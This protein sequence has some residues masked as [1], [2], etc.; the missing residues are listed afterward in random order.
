[1]KLVLS[2]VAAVAA[3]APMIAAQPERIVN[4]TDSPAFTFMGAL[5][6][7]N[8]VNERQDGKC[9]L[10]LL[11]PYY[12]LTAAICLYRCA[13][14]INCVAF[15]PIPQDLYLNN[16]DNGRIVV[17]G[18]DRADSSQFE[19]STIAGVVFHPD[20]AINPV[21]Y[22]NPNNLA[23]LRLGQPMFN[24]TPVTLSNNSAEINDIVELLGWGYTA[25]QLQSVVL[26][27][28]VMNV[29]AC[30]LPE[31]IPPFFCTQGQNLQNSLDSDACLYDQG[32]PALITTPA[33]LQQIG[34][35]VSVAPDCATGPQPQSTLINME[36]YLEWI[37]NNTVPLNNT[38][39][40]TGLDGGTPT[41]IIDGAAVP[42]I[43]VQSASSANTTATL[44]LI[45]ETFISNGTGPI[46]FT[47]TLDGVVILT[48]TQGDATPALEVSLTPGPH[49]LVIQS[50]DATGRTGFRDV[51]LIIED[52]VCLPWGCSCVLIKRIPRAAWTRSMVVWCKQN[53][54]RI[55][56]NPCSAWKCSCA[57]LKRWPAAHFT[58][59]I[60]MWWG[61]FCTAH[62]PHPY[63]SMY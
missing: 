22:A 54:P 59:L 1:M 14:E 61:T 29:T 15:E 26:Q 38:L 21:P 33:G 48:W 12:A 56:V 17:G 44:L 37:I 7:Q 30:E 4:G 13:D 39:W 60:R 46:V 31:Q 41:V 19:F 49:R 62:Q 43:G 63:K 51:D 34:M 9:G 16:L 24:L 57:V 35:I 23:I 2:I 52:A 18:A 11:T 36:P 32:G 55:P 45:P 28:T 47:A 50:T 53:C 40:I 27:S 8:R 58:N 20:W 10:T 25:A 5:D 3:V 6:I 42:V